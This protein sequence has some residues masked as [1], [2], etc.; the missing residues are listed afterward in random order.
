MLLLVHFVTPNLSLDSFGPATSP[1]RPT[2]YYIPAN[3]M[4]MLAAKEK[5][6]R[7][8]INHSGLSVK[9]DDHNNNFNFPLGSL[10]KGFF[11]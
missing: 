10:E 3:S 7:R 2:T 5:G 11:S 4:E 1:E 6:S 9:K 8:A